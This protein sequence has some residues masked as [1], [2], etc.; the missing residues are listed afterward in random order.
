MRS[1]HWRLDVP[2]STELL[3]KVLRPHLT[4]YLT[5]TDGT[6]IAFHVSKQVGSRGDE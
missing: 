5:L 4:L 2:I 6:E 3:P 1:L